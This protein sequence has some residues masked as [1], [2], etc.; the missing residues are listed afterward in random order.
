MKFFDKIK[1][2]IKESIVELKKVNWPTKKE[3]IRGSIIVICLSLGIAF[4]LGFFDYIFTI[5]LNKL[6][7][8]T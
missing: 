6:L 4:L 5:F 1:N 3:T 2:Y 7:H 8:L